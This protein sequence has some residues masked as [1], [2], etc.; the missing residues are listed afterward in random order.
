M[1]RPGDVFKYRRGLAAD[2]TTEN[3]ILDDGQAGFETDTLKQKVGDGTTAWDDLAYI[4]ADVADGDYGDITVTDAG[5]TWTIDN[6]AV[7]TAKLADAAVSTVKIA[8]GA[9]TA[10][11][12]ADA[13]ITTGK[14]NDG[15]VTAAKLATDAVTTIKV[16]DA[17]IT[18]A[19][20]A[21]MAGA[22]IKGRSSGTGAPEDLT[23]AQA[24]ALLSTFTSSTKGLVPASGGSADD[25][26][27]AN[28]SWFRV[29]KSLT[30]GTSSSGVTVTIGGGLSE[31]TVGVTLG[32][33]A[34]TNIA[35][36]GYCSI[37]ANAT[38][39]STLEV[40]G[41]LYGYADIIGS[42]GFAFSGGTT[43][44][45]ANLY[46]SGPGQYVLRST[47]SIRYKTAVRPVEWP[48]ARKALDLQ[49]IAYRSTSPHDDPEQEHLGLIA[50]DVELI[51]P[52]LVHYHDGEPDGVRY[53]RLTVLL[54][55]IVKQQQADLDAI[56]RILAT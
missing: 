51:D 27:Y 26:L 20:L 5:Q 36:P 18:N 46:Q 49:P 44:S 55:G 40:T 32:T 23:G 28:G 24:T 41:N 19:K 35:T 16:Q 50:E 31:P 54:L 37:G 2:W 30:A 39:A 53:E 13:A 29:V 47:S 14:L 42:A 10:A 7:T 25:V 8:D 17:A 15:A 22:T 6:G 3:P 9:V 11:K 4:V 34:P 1:S 48:E 21:N 33:I 56:K 52:R 43:A 45:A 12:V 38:V